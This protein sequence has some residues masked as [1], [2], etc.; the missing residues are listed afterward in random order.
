MKRCLFIVGG[1]LFLAS[2]FGGH[3]M[4]A[5]WRF[6]VGLSYVSGFS[7]VVDLYE[8]NLEAEGYIVDTTWEF[9]VGVTFQPY[10]QM[11]NGLRIGF[12]FGPM[13]FI[14]SDSSFFDIP[15]NVNGGY[16]FA[17]SSDFSPYIRLGMAYHLA[18]GDYIESASPGLLAGIGFE[19]KRN[20][21]VGF[22]IEF[23]YD[24]S[25]V[26]FASYEESY[27]WYDYSEST[28]DMKPYKS[29][30]SLFVRF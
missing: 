2:F 21:P 18:G 26:E 24:A 29:M 6:P 10:A 9:P 13:A 8:G 15:V 3:C 27:Y 25:E 28:K 16:T 7:D 22:G 1:L 5:D 14:L 19:F 4:A 17:P 11:E 12:G 20:S 23:T 30:V